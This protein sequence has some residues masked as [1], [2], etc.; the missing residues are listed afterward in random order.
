[1]TPNSF[2]NTR[3]GLGVFARPFYLIAFLWNGLVFAVGNQVPKL[4]PA[5]NVAD[6]SGLRFA[7]QFPHIRQDFQL[8]QVCASYSIMWDILIKSPYSVIFGGAT[9]FGILTW[10][11]TPAEAWLVSPHS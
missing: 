4:M 1:L 11:F 7:F 5:A 8:R 9:L 3:F 6:Y 10:W 2:K